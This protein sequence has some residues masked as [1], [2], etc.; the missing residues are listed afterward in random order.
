MTVSYDPTDLD[1]TTASGQ[2]NI[3]RRLIGDTDVDN[4]IL[5]DEEINF[6]I[7]DNN[8]DVYK[9]ASDC[10]MMI[11]NT[12]SKEVN[13]DI[14]GFIQIDFSD[15]AEQY[16]TLSASLKDK[17][18]SGTSFKFGIVGGGTTKSDYIAALNNP[19]RKQPKFIDGQFDN[20]QYGEYDDFSG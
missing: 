13:V 17:A 19:N 18:S 6:S 10:A 15:L 20:P 12:Y 1:K 9:A 4:A 7:D 8:S 16:K 2:L 5:Q 11:A 3:V 14:E